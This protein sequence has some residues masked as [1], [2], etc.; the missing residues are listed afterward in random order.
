MAGR[1]E[2]SGLNGQHRP[3][4]A[5]VYSSSHERQIDHGEIDLGLRDQITC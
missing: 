1:I 4:C 2:A 3:E 5:T